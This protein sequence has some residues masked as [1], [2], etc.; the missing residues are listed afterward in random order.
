MAPTGITDADVGAP[1]VDGP[2]PSPKS[3]MTFSS[4]S[5][6]INGFPKHN[7]GGRWLTMR[8]SNLRGLDPFIQ[9]VQQR[10]RHASMEETPLPPSPHYLQCTNRSPRLIEQ[11][12]VG[13][14][15]AS[16]A[17]ISPALEYECPRSTPPPHCLLAAWLAPV[18]K[19]A[20]RET[21]GKLNGGSSM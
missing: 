3:T 1:H 13:D 12:G 21:R 8:R 14:M 2:S 15:S 19:R 17:S 11:I 16:R 4:V 7:D 18:A 5:N 20:K 9:M 10:R 6:S